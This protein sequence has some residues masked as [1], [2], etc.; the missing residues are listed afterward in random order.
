MKAKTLLLATALLAGAV[1]LPG[2]GRDVKDDAMSVLKE[3]GVTHCSDI[4]NIKEA[5]K[6]SYTATA[7]LKDGR[8]PEIDIM[9][10]DDTVWV[11]DR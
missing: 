8:T 1:L 2:C 9:Y 3:N 6:D 7:I 4:V 11:K 5:G 10:C